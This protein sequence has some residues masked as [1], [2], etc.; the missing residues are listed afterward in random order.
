MTALPIIGRELALTKSLALLVRG[1]AIK[2]HE[3]TQLRELPRGFRFDVHMFDGDEP[4]DRV[5][6]VTVEFDRVGAS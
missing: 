6:R 4:T 2:R 5:A 3:T 1:A